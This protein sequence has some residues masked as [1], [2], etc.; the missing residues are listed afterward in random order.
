M[1]H[2]NVIFNLKRFIEVINGAD[3]WLS[4]FQYV[5]APKEEWVTLAHAVYD[6][7]TDSLQPPGITKVFCR[8]FFS[9]SDMTL[10]QLIKHCQLDSDEVKLLYD[11]IDVKRPMFWRLIGEIKKNSP[12]PNTKQGLISSYMASNPGIPLSLD[13][14]V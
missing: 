4:H 3:Y 6:L 5:K 2:N 11:L 10:D 8:C 13:V 7:F 1:Q 14:A 12:A 9:D